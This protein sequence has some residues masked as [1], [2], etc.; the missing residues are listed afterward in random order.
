MTRAFDLFA[1]VALASLTAMAI[2]RGVGL[3]RRGVNVLPIDRERTVGQSLLDL[4]FLVAFLVW[5]YEAIAQAVPLGLHAVPQPWLA[6]WLDAPIAKA[7]G[8]LVTAAGLLVYG[9]ALRDF[10]ASWRLGIDREHAGAL[11]TTGIF[12]RSRNPVYVGLL[13]VQTGSFLLLGSVVLLG[14]TLFSAAYFRALVAREE[15]FLAERHGGDY[16]AYRA[17][18][19][20]WWSFDRA[21]VGRWWSFDRAG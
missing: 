4:L 15:R 20:R 21:R 3:R 12:A 8:A 19:G 16:A 6:I 1:L 7:L 10:G 17:R 11:V 18:V 13:L 2:S 9:R 5:F 14:A